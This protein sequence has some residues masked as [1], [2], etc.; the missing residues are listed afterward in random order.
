VLQRYG[1]SV[2]GEGRRAGVD[3]TVFKNLGTFL[4]S[5]KRFKLY[6]LLNLLKNVPS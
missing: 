6:S 4:L 2:E 3:D 1:E 5:L